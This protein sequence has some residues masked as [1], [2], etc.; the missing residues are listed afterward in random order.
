MR[1]LNKPLYMYLMLFSFTTIVGT[2]LLYLPITG[3]KPLNFVDAFFISASAFTVTGLATIDISSQFN[4]LGDTIILLL[5][6]IG[7]L[8]IVTVTLL[9]LILMHRKISLR[10]RYLIMTT[11]N[12]ESPGGV[13]KLILQFVIYSILTEFIGAICIALSFI[14]KYGLGKGIF[15]SAFTS[16]SAFNNAGF[17]LFSDNMMGTVNDPIITMIVPILIIMG[18]IGPLVFLDVATTRKLS[19]LTLHSKIVLTTSVILILIGWVVF[20]FLEYNHSMAHLSFLEK[21]G[22]S[23]FQSVTTRTAG[24][25]SVDIGQI[26][27]PTSILLMLLMFIGG[28]P[29]SAAGG[30][31]VTTLVLTLLF[32]KSTLRNEQHPSIFKKSINEHTLKT[33]VAITFSAGAFVIIVSF[34]VS[35]INSAIS[36]TKV[37][38]EV[39]SAFGTVG[40]SMN[41]TTFYDSPTKIVIVLTMLIGKIGI[42]TFLQLFITEKNQKFHYAKENVHL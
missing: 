6:Q 28:A 2:L 26:T 40:L 31:K 21:L 3:V 10:N 17:S 18:G 11:W 25:N 4:W 38:F 13:I 20:Y 37:L 5:I 29:I 34:I 16:I 33:A 22:A 32:I 23:F 39:I 27:P 9:T 1:L 30:I 7:G 41:F 15:L 14:P 12:I 35:Y 19:K 24:F 36:Y 42:L 8:G